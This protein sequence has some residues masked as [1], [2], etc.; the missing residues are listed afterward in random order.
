VKVFAY[1]HD[2]KEMP[3]YI[4]LCIKVMEGV[5]GDDFALYERESFIREFPDVRKDIWTFEH[6]Q[7]GINSHCSRSN[8][9][10]SHLLKKYGGFWIDADTI[11]VNNFFEELNLLLK[12]MI[13]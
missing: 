10:R 11:V 6:H 8:Y 3:P 2:L 9:I 5:F 7:G 12:N 13:T 1:W 4:G